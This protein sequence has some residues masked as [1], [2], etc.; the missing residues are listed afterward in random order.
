M[1]LYEFTCQSCRD[2]FE[3]LVRGKETLECPKC[4]SE[5]IEKQFSVVAAHSGSSRELP[6]CDAPSNEGG[7]GLPQCGGGQCGMPF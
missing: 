5:T 6:V 1:P 3:L 7:C 4:G 2:E